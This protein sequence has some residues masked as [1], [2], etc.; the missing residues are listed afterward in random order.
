MNRENP[1]REV[2]VI[3]AIKL[4]IYRGNGT[5]GD[6][7]RQNI[8]IWTMDGKLL[9]DDDKSNLEGEKYDCDKLQGFQ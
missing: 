7:A 8:Q 4:T 6:P 3:S 5:S 1:I 2:E 9:F